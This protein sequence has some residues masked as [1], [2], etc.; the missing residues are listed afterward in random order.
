MY[1]SY[2]ENN[3]PTQTIQETLQIMRRDTYAVLDHFGRRNL[4][5]PGQR[6]P[7]ELAPVAPA[8]A[9]LAAHPSLHNFPNVQFRGS[10]RTT[11]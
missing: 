5:S 4:F 7:M 2:P 11:G 8:S 1:V 10:N 9:A 6:L 3:I